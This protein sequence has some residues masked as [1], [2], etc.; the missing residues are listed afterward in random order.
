MERLKLNPEEREYSKYDKPVYQ[1]FKQLVVLDSIDAL[2]YPVFCLIRRYSTI[3][4]YSILFNS[5]LK[6]F[7]RYTSCNNRLDTFIKV[8]KHYTILEASKFIHSNNSKNY[9]N[10]K[11]LVFSEDFDEVY[12]F[13]MQI[14]TESFGRLLIESVESSV[15]IMTT[16]NQ[17][18]QDLSDLQNGPHSL[19]SY[20]YNLFEG[21]HVF[22]DLSKIE[23]NKNLLKA[24]GYFYVLSNGTNCYKELRDIF[25]CKGYLEF[26]NIENISYSKEKPS[27]NL[28][29][30][31]EVLNM[32]LDDF[33]TKR[34]VAYA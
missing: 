14:D 15:D 11:D 5:Y 20:F 26:K 3:E 28:E 12:L 21:K 16:E 27:L 7:I 34:H 33:R 4:S 17:F 18:L 22:I 30:S 2:D 1:M 25:D 8:L 6:N 24:L 10:V 29:V 32:A 19:A 31:R 9:Q 13:P 23:R